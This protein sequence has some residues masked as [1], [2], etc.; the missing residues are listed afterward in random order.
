M[1]PNLSWVVLLVAVF[2]LVGWK[3]NGHRA[4]GQT[5]GA[6]EYKVVA[7]E[8]IGVEKRGEPERTLNRL[9]AEGWEMVQMNPYEAASAAE[10]RGSFLLKRAK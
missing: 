3:S 9:G 7:V 10:W 4:S 2:C 8:T 5:P 1:K 6:W